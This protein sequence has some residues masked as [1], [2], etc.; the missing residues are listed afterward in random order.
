MKIKKYRLVCGCLSFFG[1]LFRLVAALVNM[2][3]NYLPHERQVAT[4]VRA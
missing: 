4:Q 2:A 1:G 3:S